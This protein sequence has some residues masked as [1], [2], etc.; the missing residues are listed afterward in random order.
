M[1]NENGHTIVPTSVSVNLAGGLFAASPVFPDGPK[2]PLKFVN[3]NDYNNQF[4]SNPVLFWGTNNLFPDELNA[5]TRKSGIAQR[6][7]KVRQQ[8][9]YDQGVIT[10]KEIVS[11]AGETSIQ[12]VQDKKVNE[13]LKKININK[14]YAEASRDYERYGNVFPIIQLAEDRKV[15]AISVRKARH[16]RL[17]KHH[18]MTGRIEN[19][20]ESAQWSNGL[21][22][23]SSQIPAELKK[24]VNKYP[25]LEIDD[26]AD[27][28][29]AMPK[30]Y[31]FALHLRETS[32]DGD[33]GESPW[34][35]CFYNGW[36]EISSNV[37][38][39]K[40]RLFQYAMT[41]N[42]VVYIDDAYWVTVYGD[43]FTKW[44]GKQRADAIQDLQDN[45]EKNL[46]GKDNA[47]KSLFASLK[48]T[49]DGKEKKS[50]IVEA[51]DNKLREG[52][53]IPDNLHA[54][55]EI[56]TAMGLDAC[57]YGASV[58]GDK[59]SSGSGS[60]IREQRLNTT[61]LMTIDRDNLFTPVYIG[62]ELMGF[63]PE[64]KY[65]IKALVINNLDGTRPVASSEATIK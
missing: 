33:Y 56:T 24:W 35:A 17:E 47:W 5:A 4:E 59:V 16:C 3:E 28:I 8:L 60:P 18:P 38:L 29:F 61:G 15:A 62:H 52:T 1:G 64:I 19:I 12:I 55:G 39:L 25:L 63:D 20:Y 31:N 57:L 32:S 30:D 7:L 65:G 49:A 14:Y 37:P 54:N 45:I 42:Y 27:Q 13:W 36:L 44:K 23:K 11:A 50:I 51:I 53:F 21:E 34:H 58:L 22:L 6:G 10:Y 48:Y 41:L 43:E 9:M 40:K 26:A 2:I 46:L